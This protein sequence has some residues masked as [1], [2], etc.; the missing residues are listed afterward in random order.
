LEGSIQISRNTTSTL[1]QPGQQARISKEGKIEIINDADVEEAIAWKEGKF[2]F[3]RA[4]IHTVMRQIA[5][6]YDVEVEY[7]GPVNSHFGGTISRDV[8]LLQV[9]NMLHLTGEVNFNIQDKKIVVMPGP[10]KDDF[11]K[12]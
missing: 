4:E 7:G 1:L 6:W 12:H 10:G 9:L 2:Q 11:S 8:N 5:R 3:N